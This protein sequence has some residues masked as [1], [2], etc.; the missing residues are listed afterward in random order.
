MKRCFELADEAEKRGDTSVGSLIADKK[1]KIIAEASELNRTESPFAHS[2]ILA[3]KRA[4]E[5][6][7][8]LSGCQI[9]TTNEPCFLCSFAI[10]ETNI[11]R[12]VYVKA[13]PQIGG[14]TSSYPILTAADISKWGNPPEIIQL[15]DF[16]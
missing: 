14:A 8:D 5:I 13:S 4:L 12:V 16:G 7:N 15:T 10:R 6:K 1:G 2:E 11:A 3:V 9:Y